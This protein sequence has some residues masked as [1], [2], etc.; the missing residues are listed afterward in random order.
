[1]DIDGPSTFLAETLVLES[2]KP[3]VLLAQA[4]LRAPLGA[5]IAVA[6]NATREAV[7]AVGAALPP[8]CAARQVDVLELN[9]VSTHDSSLP[10]ADIS[11]HLARHGINLRASKSFGTYK[12]VGETLR[13][14]WPTVRICW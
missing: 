9:P 10:A 8:L 7:R 12:N 3:V 5:H 13:A 2:G 4:E 14:R 11:T 6:W 1:M